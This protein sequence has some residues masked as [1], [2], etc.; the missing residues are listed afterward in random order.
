MHNHIIIKE[1]EDRKNDKKIKGSN[2]YILC[3]EQGNNSTI[4]FWPKEV[5]CFFKMI[6]VRSSTFEKLAMFFIGIQKKTIRKK[7]YDVNIAT[8]IIFVEH[9]PKIQFIANMFSIQNG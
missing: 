5:S 6:E 7:K 4:F 2:T 1:E 9:I 3:V 8:K